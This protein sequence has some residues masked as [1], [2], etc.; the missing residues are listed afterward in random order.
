MLHLGID[1]DEWPDSRSDRCDSVYLQGAH[2][3]G[4]SVGLLYG[5]YR[6]DK[7]VKTCLPPVWN[8]YPELWRMFNKLDPQNVAVVQPWILWQWEQSSAQPRTLAERG[9]IKRKAV[10]PIR[11]GTDTLCI[12]LSQLPASMSAGTCGLHAFCARIYRG[13]LYITGLWVHTHISHYSQ[14]F[15]IIVLLIFLHFDNLREPKDY[16]VSYVQR[17]N[18]YYTCCSVQVN[19]GPT[20]IHRSYVSA[21]CEDDCVV[22]YCTLQ[23]GRNWPIFVRYLTA[24][25][26]M[27]M[28]KTGRLSV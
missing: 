26:T 5:C 23:S 20:V 27:A 25:V 2:W 7:Y 3:R 4:S 12:S 22:E 1:G 24:S 16:F 8:R 21:V 18:V 19:V 15:Q 10:P 28:I 6:K 17:N 14:G 9:S 11:E 13:Y